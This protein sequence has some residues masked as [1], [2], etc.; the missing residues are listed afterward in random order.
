[1][2]RLIADILWPIFIHSNLKFQQA[3]DLYDA[4]LSEKI[5]TFYASSGAS[6]RKAYELS[7]AKRLIQ[8]RGLKVWV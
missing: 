5:R 8:V 3:G 1:M 2:K 7:P 4:A 6:V